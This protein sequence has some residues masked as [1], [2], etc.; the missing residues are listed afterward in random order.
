V[1]KAQPGAA[2][3]RTAQLFRG[4]PRAHGIFE[5]LPRPAGGKKV[6]GKARTVRGDVTPQLWRDHLDGKAGLG[7]VPINDEAI[8]YFGAIDVDKYDLNLAE[9]EKSVR[10]NGLPLL[11]CRT[12]SAGAHL[13]CFCAEGVPA[14]LL[15]ARLEEW[16]VVL[17]Y[18][19]SEIFPKQAKL[20][21][22]SD[23]GNWI[24]MPYF[25]GDK[26]DRYCIFKGEKLSFADFLDLAEA[27]AKGLTAQRL[28]ELV[29]PVGDEFENGPPCLQS[30]IRRGGFTEGMR[31][32][33]LFAVGIYLKKRFP[34]DWRQKLAQYNANYFHPAVPDQEVKSS[35]LKSLNREKDYN[36][37]CTK[38]PI[39]RFCNK[40]LCMQ[41]E[42]GVGQGTGE[43]NVV[44]DTDVLKVLTDPPFW[45]LT[46]N[47]TR[48]QFFADELFRQATFQRIVFNAINIK[49]STLPGPKWDAVLNEIG[50]NSQDVPAPEGAG[51][52]GELLYHL[53][54]FCTVFTQAETREEVLVGK[55]FTEDGWTYFRGDA[56]KQ[57]LENKRVKF[58]NM[59]RIFAILKTRGAEPRQLR[60]NK[61]NP[62]LHV[63]AVPEQERMTTDVP[64]RKVDKGEM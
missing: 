6:E 40:S 39:V 45:I 2:W 11:L 18:A 48:M 27:T 52:V 43:W 32:N 4:L 23:V 3:Q 1:G 61:D 42:F 10:E 17:G 54:Q 63:W 41:R 24:N 58:E 46:V 47:G 59:A 13:Y 33:G 14:S 22:T 19:G 53:R 25:A 8:C 38:H 64:P 21:N 57:Y 28:A 49:P 12:K 29:I 35:V 20:M 60:L 51:T 31:N 55:P 34:D 50:K 44:V 16:S 62:N 26:T 7:I 15:K 56:F 37:P 9:V 36:Y 5:L 30:I